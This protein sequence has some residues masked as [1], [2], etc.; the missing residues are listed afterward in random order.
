[1]SLPP[2]KFLAPGLVT[3]GILIAT[4]FAW[5]TGQ[6]DPSTGASNAAASDRN[7]RISEAS[8][9]SVQ[10]SVPMDEQSVK[11]H[12]VIEPKIEG[13]VEWS[14]HQT[15]VFQPASPLSRSGTYTLTIAP[16][17]VRRDKAVLGKSIVMRYFVAGPP[18]VSQQLPPQE[19]AG[20]ALDQRVTLVFDR[21]VVALTTLSQRQNQFTD[22]PVTIAPP[23][24]GTWKW[25]STT[26]AEFSPKKGFSPAT[27]YRVNVPAGIKTVNGEV[28]TEDQSWSFT[29]QKPQIQRTTP[30]D[31]FQSSS[32]KT[33]IVLEFNLSMDLESAKS[34]I[35][36]VRAV[37]KD[38]SD[39]ALGAMRGTS[40]DPAIA[41]LVP[42]TLSYGTKEENGKKNHRK[43]RKRA[44]SQCPVRPR[45]R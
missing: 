23:I 5:M 10:F 29:T 22:W 30:P 33:D 13:T 9:L 34:H 31:G 27:I 28:T 32:P 8:P 41:T 15:M 36:L 7:Q 44:L 18:R 4:G 2:R 40:P 24:E 35:L 6:T 3:L 19:E 25:L 38:L 20:V 17:A 1:M 12:M 42:V 45:C 11:E 14:N 39:E 16:E 21:P 26:T 37:K 43:T